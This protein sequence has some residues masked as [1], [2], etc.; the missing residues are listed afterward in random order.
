MRDDQKGKAQL[1]EERYKELFDNMAEGV[2]IYEAVDD[3]QDFVFVDYNKAGQ[4]MDG[5]ALKDALGKRVSE[6]FPGVK[7]FGLFEV[8]QRVWRTGEP[9]QHPVSLYRDD[10]LS[11]YRANYVY[12]LP[13]GQ[14]VAVYSDETKRK[15]AELAVQAERDRLNAVFA[16]MDDGV[17][18]VDQDYN[19]EFVNAVL[20]KTFGPYENRKC[21]AYFHDLDKACPWCKNPDV[22]AGKTVRWE[23]YSEKADKTYDLIDTPL[24]NADGRDQQPVGLCAVQSREPDRRSAATISANPID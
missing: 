4:S 2:A 20:S 11:F 1:I 3:G 9:E 12:K 24:R 10:N 5:I 7:E 13:G 8:L 19:I 17:Y 23:W 15:Q 22:F 16:A 21:Y 6:V 14:I 18:I